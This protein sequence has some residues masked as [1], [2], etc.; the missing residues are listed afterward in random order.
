M[1]VRKQTNGTSSHTVFPEPFQPTMSVS[2]VVKTIVS[3]FSGPKERM[4]WIIMRSIFDM[5]ATV[6]NALS[7][8]AIEAECAPSRS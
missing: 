3:P 2:G 1:S 4:P 7:H 8:Q 6:C 5:M